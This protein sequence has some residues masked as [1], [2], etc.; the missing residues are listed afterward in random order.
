MSFSK[1]ALL[2]TGIIS[3]LFF[4]PISLAAEKSTLCK[5]ESGPKAGQTIDYAPK[6]AIPVGSACWD[7]DKSHGHVVAKKK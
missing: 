6:P 2:W 1:R 5:F 4:S 7:G 3:C